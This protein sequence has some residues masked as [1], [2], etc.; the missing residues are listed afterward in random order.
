MVNL[1][2]PDLKQ[3]NVHEPSWRTLAEAQES[4]WTSPGKDSSISSKSAGQSAHS[5]LPLILLYLFLRAS[6]SPLTVNLT[7]IVQITTLI[8]GNWT[9]PCGAV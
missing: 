4:E 3:S 8:R 9:G 2:K 5:P 1:G 6:R 7:S